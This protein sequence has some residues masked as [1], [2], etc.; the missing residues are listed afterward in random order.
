MKKS[1][2]LIT[3]VV[4]ICLGSWVSSAVAGDQGGLKAL[5]PDGLLDAGGEAVS[6]ESLEGKGVV[7]IYFSAH[8]CGPCRQ[9][10]PQLV[11]YRDAQQ[12]DIEV[13]FVSSDRSEEKQFEYMKEAG[14]KWLTVKYNSD[15]ANAL[16][17]K[18]EIRGIPTLVLVNGDGELISMGG[19]QLVT[20]EVAAEKIAAARVVSEEYKCDNC[21]KTHTRE[22]LVFD[23]DS[24]DTD[25]T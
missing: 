15:A 19:R 4:G 21:D 7:G 6:V 17:K 23:D 3:V 5:F 12:D 11:K 14:M 9:F 24:Q 2:R 8:W 16:K 18:Y 20:D 25:P 1:I 22:R 13:V 10:T